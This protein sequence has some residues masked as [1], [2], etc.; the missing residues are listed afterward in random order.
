M[1]ASVETACTGP[2][3]HA[4][5]GITGENDDDSDTYTG[6]RAGTMGTLL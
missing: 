4:N 5:D 3:P 2:K 1:N 6:A